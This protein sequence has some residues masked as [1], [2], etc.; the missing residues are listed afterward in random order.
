MYVEYSNGIFPCDTLF[1]KSEDEWYSWFFSISP[2][3]PKEFVELLSSRTTDSRAVRLANQFLKM[4][5][6]AKI[7]IMN[8]AT[9]PT[10]MNTVPEGALDLQMFGLSPAAGGVISGVVHVVDPAS[11]TVITGM[12]DLVADVVVDVIVGIPDDDICTE[13]FSKELCGW[14]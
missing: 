4:S 7:T 2:P 14:F 5:T 9:A 13:R 11:V 8:P 3:D 10:A 1:L 6:R 12:P